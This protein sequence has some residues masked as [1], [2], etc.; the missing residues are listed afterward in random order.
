MKDKPKFIIINDV[1][2]LVDESSLI[3]K[4]DLIEKETDTISKHVSRF[5]IGMVVKTKNSLGECIGVVAQVLCG[6][7]AGR[8]RNFRSKYAI[9][10]LNKDELPDRFSAWYDE[11]DM[12]LV[13]D[14]L[15]YG[16]KLL[17]YYERNRKRK[18]H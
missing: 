8:D 7:E 11:D 3:R 17:S 10:V 2:F 13:C 12:Q 1:G 15:E 14:N 18:V 9:I 4:N 16:Y 6:Y 5:K